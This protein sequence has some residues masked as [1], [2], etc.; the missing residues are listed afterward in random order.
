[1]DRA[2]WLRRLATE[3]GVI[4]VGVLVALLAESWWQERGERVEERVTLERLSG[5]L[6]ADSTLVALW[7]EWLGLVGPGFDG[8][9]AALQGRSTLGPAGDLAL[10]YAAATEVTTDRPVG[11]WDELSASGR[12]ADIS[13]PDLREAIVAFYTTFTDLETYGRG[14]PDAYRITVTSVVPSSVTSSILAECLREEAS[15]PEGR[16]QRGPRA[17]AVQSLQS[18]AAV[19]SGEARGYLELLGR[20]EGFREALEARAYEAG[21]LRETHALLAVR[22]DSLRMQL[23]RVLA[24]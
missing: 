15:N 23:D 12:L 19:G 4:V 3:F 20:R 21:L 8:A 11:V 7:G 9:R 2:V 1:M 17:D 6:E 13:D 14:L 22:F 16:V 10:T 5:E 18:C 24:R